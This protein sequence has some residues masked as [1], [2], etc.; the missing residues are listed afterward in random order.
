MMK[1]KKLTWEETAAFPLAFLTAYHM[2]IKKL[3]LKE[4]RI[5]ESIVSIKKELH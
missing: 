5:C 1:P 4:L 2:L 3:K